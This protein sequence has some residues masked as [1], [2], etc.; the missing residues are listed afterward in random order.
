MRFGGQP[1][2]VVVLGITERVLENKIISAGSIDVVRPAWALVDFFYR[3]IGGIVIDGIE[4]R[5]Q[6]VKHDVRLSSV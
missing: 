4:A 3:T 2:L 6:K 5:I 1:H